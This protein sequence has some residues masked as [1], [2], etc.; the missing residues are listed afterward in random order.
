MRFSDIR[1]GKK[2]PDGHVPA[3]P[4]VVQSVRDD[5]GNP[6]RDMLTGRR[7][8]RAMKF[9]AR[10]E[11]PLRSRVQRTRRKQRTGGVK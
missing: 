6:V 4:A 3:K 7:A 1:A 9:G 8:R 5:N 10:M 2:T 11:Q